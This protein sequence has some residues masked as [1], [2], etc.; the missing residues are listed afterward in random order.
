MLIVWLRE[1]DHYDNGL[2]VLT[3][4]TYWIQPITVFDDQTLNAS[5]VSIRDYSHS[6]WRILRANLQGGNAHSFY[7][8]PTRWWWLEWAVMGRDKTLSQFFEDD[9][10]RQIWHFDIDC[11]FKPNIWWTGDI[12]ALS[13][14]ESTAPRHSPRWSSRKIRNSDGSS[15]WPMANIV[16]SS[17]ICWAKMS[18]DAHRSM[19]DVGCSSEMF[20]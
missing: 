8:N 20:W 9:S 17:L 5:N 10:L 19:R 4:T 18:A 7:I 13:M 2:I 14:R 11:R 12:D 6:W 1:K 16:E 3:I 15:C